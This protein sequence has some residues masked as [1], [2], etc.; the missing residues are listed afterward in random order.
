MAMAESFQFQRDRCLHNKLRDYHAHAK[1]FTRATRGTSKL[2]PGARNRWI[3][4][5]NKIDT[6]RNQSITINRL[7]LEIDEQSMRQDSVTFHRFS[8]IAERKR[9]SNQ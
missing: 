7:I 5:L 1:P 8:S 9:K 6:N 2:N 3:C 4:Q